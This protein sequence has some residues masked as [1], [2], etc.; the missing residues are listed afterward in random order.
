MNDTRKAIIE[1]IEPYM[2]KD[3]VKWCIIKTHHKLENTYNIVELTQAIINSDWHITTDWKWNN[4]LR[5]DTDTQFRILWHY[6]IS[7]VLKYIEYTQKCSTGIVEIL[8]DVINI[9]MKRGKKWVKI[10]NKPLHLYTEQEDKDLL[11]LLNKL[12]NTCTTD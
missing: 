10:P 3:L 12:N 2:A 6:D 11:E 8:S 1:L 4:I 5:S 9:A 7:A